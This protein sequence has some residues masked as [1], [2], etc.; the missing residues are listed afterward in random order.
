MIYRPKKGQRVQVRYNKKHRSNVQAL[1]EWIGQTEPV[2]HETLGTVERVASGQRCVNVEVL[3]D[4]GTSAIV[5]RGN[6]FAV[7]GAE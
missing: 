1:A 3:L 2:C 7:K 5:P 4:N 6:L